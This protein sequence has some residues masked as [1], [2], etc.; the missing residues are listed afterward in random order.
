MA[1][2][3]DDLPVLVIDGTRRGEGPTLFDMIINIIRDHGPVVTSP[4]TTSS[5]S[6]SDRERGNG[7]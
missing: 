2:H 3:S 7:A 5:W 4:K 1:D 6:C